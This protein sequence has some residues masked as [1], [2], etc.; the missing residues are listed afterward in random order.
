ME[1]NRI[2]KSYILDSDLAIIWE[3]ESIRDFGKEL[4]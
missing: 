4:K 3:G 1:E 2:V